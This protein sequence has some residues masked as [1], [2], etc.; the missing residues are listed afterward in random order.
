[1]FFRG[2][3]FFRVFS[4]VAVGLLLYNSCTLSAQEVSSELL[5]LHDSLDAITIPAPTY[6]AFQRDMLLYV[7]NQEQ[8]NNIA[9]EIEKSIQEGARNICVRVRT[10]TLELTSDI[11]G[12]VNINEP[13]A[14]IL[15]EGNGVVCISGGPV[16]SK[17]DAKVEQGKTHYSFPLTGF[18]INDVLYDGKNRHIPIIDNSFLI[19][20]T[21]EPVESEG[22]EEIKN[23]DGSLYKRITRIWRFRTNLPNIEENECRNFYILLTRNWTSCRHRVKKIQDGYLYFYL[24]SDDA[25]TLMQMTLNPNS[26]RKTYNV[27]PRCRFINSPT[28]KGV[29]FKQ[30]VIYIPNKIKR[31]RVGKGGTLLSLN[32]CHL[33]SF[34]VSGFRIICAGNNPCIS[35]QSSSFDDQMWIMD[36]TFNNLSNRAVKVLDCENVC[37]INNKINGTRINAIYCSGNNISIEGN[38]LRNI[39]YM[40]Q[41]M[42]IAFLGTDIHIYDNII[43]DF[44][45][46][47][48]STGGTQPN[49]N[50]DP[51]TYIIERN[52]IRYTPKFL[53]HYKDN[54]LADGGGIYIGPQNTQGIIRYNII[55]NITGMGANRGIFLDD[56]AKN[57]SIY[58]NLIMNTSNS[59]DIDLRLSNTYAAGIPDH[60]TNNKVF[61]NIITGRYRFQDNGATDS[62]CIGGENILLELNNKLSDV[63]INKQIQ[64]FPVK[65]CKYRKGI[66]VIAR[67]Y[68][69]TLSIIKADDFILNSIMLR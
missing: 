38:E 53:K 13:D 25:P 32:N 39:G 61:H 57:L 59:S 56:G 42:A 31:I 63:Q 66:I 15:I 35:V 40:G 2:I 29:Y 46:S 30:N 51:K 3:D 16:I 22:I 62:R 7:D 58:G 1:M 54:T 9:Q 6:R 68:N 11:K 26:D 34:K 48:I 50:C 24:K 4:F 17:K 27:F 43:E 60:N 45:Y 47:A 41:T 67:G 36:N 44:N 18:S 10:K 12:F 52:T 69:T 37:V 64:D 21:I 5:E 8:W 19:D 14:N 33:N 20:S 28:R 49:N 23:S 55:D 65:G